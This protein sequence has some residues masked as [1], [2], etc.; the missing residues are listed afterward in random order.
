MKMRSKY[1]ALWM[2]TDEEMRVSKTDEWRYRRPVINHDKCRRCGW[3]A[4][5][6]IAGCIKVEKDRFVPDLN[7]CKGCGVCANECPAEAIALV[8]EEVVS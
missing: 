4:I 8:R 2:D 7:Y 1:Q 6:C 3:C 5:Y